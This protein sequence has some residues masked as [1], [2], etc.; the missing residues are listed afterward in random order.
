MLITNLDSESN[1]RNVFE[2]NLKDSKNIRIASGYFGGSEIDRYEEHFYQVAKSGGVVQLIHGMGGAEGIKRNLYKKLS[3]LDAKLKKTNPNNRVLVHKTRYH[4][5]LYI[6]DGETK[7]VL[8]GSSNFSI[9]GFGGNV[10]LNHNH[11][12]PKLFG[13]ANTF[14]ETL[15]KNSIPLTDIRLPDPKP[16][17]VEP[18]KYIGFDTKVFNGKPDYQIPIHITAGSNLNLF[19]SKGRLTSKTGTY[20]PRPFFEVELSIS[21]NEIDGLKP[22]ITDQLNPAIFS[23]V[24]EIGSTFEVNFKRKTK[25]REDKRTL[26]NISIDFMSSPRNELGHYIK[27]KLMR[28]GLLNFGEPVTEDT[29]LEYGKDKLDLYFKE[30][31]IIYIKF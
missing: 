29:L 19:M 1:F 24:T 8:I 16:S 6:T 13:N 5:K 31:G 23:A 22:H 17:F 2:Q 4:G 26:H 28:E 14:F 15:R 11:T 10:E 25:N 20:I 3:N 12:D 27:E 7:N 21:I 9:S 30:E 18:K